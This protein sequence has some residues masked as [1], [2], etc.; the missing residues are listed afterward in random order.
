[1]IFK[2]SIT[3]VI[4]TVFIFLSLSLIIPAANA[5]AY[6]PDFDFSAVKKNGDLFQRHS[7]DIDGD[8]DTETIALQAYNMQVSK[9]GDTE[10]IMSYCGLLTVLKKDAASANG[11]KILW[12]AKPAPASENNSRNLIDFMFCDFGLEPIEALGNITTAAVELISPVLQSDLRPV[13]Y[14]LIRWDNNKKEFNLVKFGVLNG[15]LDNPDKFA[16]SEYKDEY[17]EKCSWIGKIKKIKSPGVV[18]AEIWRYNN[19]M[20][21]VGIAVL[22]YEKDEFKVDNWIEKLKLIEQ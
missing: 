18:E 17:V 5:N 15:A 8:G 12:Q 19:N 13:T 10:E 3:A 6:G 14:R 21:M 16:W 20:P 22:K 7:L 1:M 11:E 2:T 9:E 4:I